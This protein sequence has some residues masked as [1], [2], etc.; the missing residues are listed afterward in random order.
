MVTTVSV[1][2]GTVHV[3]VVEDVLLY[4]IKLEY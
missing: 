3:V 2:T 4:D 1:T